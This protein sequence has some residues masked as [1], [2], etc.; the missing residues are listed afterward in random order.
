ML[1]RSAYPCRN[2][3]AASLLLL[4]NDG[5]LSIKNVE[6]AEYL[7][8]SYRHMMHRISELCSEGI[9]ERVPKGLRILDWN[10]VYS[11]ANEIQEHR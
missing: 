5:I 7:A 1:F 3:F 6:L 11:L 2:N 9:V 4:Q 10:Q 8:I